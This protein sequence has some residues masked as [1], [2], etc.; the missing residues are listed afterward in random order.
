MKRARVTGYKRGRGGF[1]I[2]KCF[3]LIMRLC[4]SILRRFLPLLPVL[5]VAALFLLPRT[6]HLRLVYKFKGP[7]SA[8]NRYYTAC[9]YFGI[10]GSVQKVFGHDCPIIAFI[11]KKSQF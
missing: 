3:H 11:E 5:V 7:F 9:H 4:L 8:E 6:P 10:H 2:A 1:G